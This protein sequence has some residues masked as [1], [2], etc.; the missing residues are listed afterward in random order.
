MTNGKNLH[1]CLFYSAGGSRMKIN[2]RINIINISML[3]ILMLLVAG[4]VNFTVRGVFEENIE[5]RELTFVEQVAEELTNPLQ[6]NDFANIQQVIDNIEMRNRYIRY[7]YVVDYDGSV[8]AHTF[9]PGIPVELT[10]ANPIPSGESFSI[11]ILSFEGESVHDIGA[12]IPDGI[13]AKVYFGFSREPILNSMNTI[14]NT[15]VSIFALFLLLSVVT[16]FFVTRTITR[17]IELLLEGTTKIGEGNIDYRID[18]EG[19]DEIEELAKGINRMTEDLKTSEAKYCSVADSVN[20]LIYLLDHDLHFMTCNR[21]SLECMG[22]SKEDVIGKPLVEIIHDPDKKKFYHKNLQ[23]ILRSGVPETH[24]VEFDV[25]GQKRYYTLTMTPVFGP[26]GKVTAIACVGCDITVRKQL[27]KKLQESEERYRKLVDQAPDSITVVREG[28]LIF[29]NPAMVK[30]LGA[31]GPEELLG[32]MI[33]DFSPPENRELLIERAQHILDTHEPAKL[34]EEKILRMDGSLLDVEVTASFI[35]YEGEPAIQTLVHDITERK[36]TEEEILFKHKQLLSIFDS[37]DE[38]VYIAD[39]VTYELLYYNEAFRSRFGDT[40]GDKCYKVIQDGTSPCSFCTNKYIFGKNLG[41]TYIWEWQNLVDSHW[42]RCIDKAIK[43]PDER[44]VRYEMAIDVTER[45]MFEEALQEQKEFAANLVQYSATPT[46]VLDSQHKVLYWNIACENLTGF[47]ASEVV[48]IED[49]WKSPYDHKRP[50]L[51]DIIISGES[52]NYLELYSIFGPSVHISNGLHA[53][54]WFQNVGGKKRYL[55]FD[56]API[57]NREGDLI[58]AV[59]TIQDFTER[60]RTEEALRKEKY[61]SETLVQS[62]PT[63]YVAINSR[64][65]TIMMNKAMLQAIGYTLEEVVGTDY[66]TTFV[67]EPERDMLLGIF[68]DIYSKK[69]TFNENSVLTKDGRELLVEWR[70]RPILKENNELDFFFGVGIDITERRFVE[71]ERRKYAEELRRSNELK[72]LF[73]DILR[74]DLLNP[75]SIVKGYI[76]VLLDVED[77][78]KKLQSIY[79]IKRNN[80]K[81]IDMIETASS[82]AKLESTEKF[83]FKE[84]DIR[85]IFKEV[86]KNFSSVLEEKK[87]ILEF[88]ADGTYL[89]MVNPVIEEAFANLL[90]NAI[91]YSPKESKIIIDIVDAG[92]NWKVSVTDFG[93]G[94]SDDDKPKLFERFR[95]VK[96]GAV[97]GTGLGL[98]IVKRLIALHG[99]TVGVEDNP[100]GQGSVFWVTVKKT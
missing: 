68:D 58:A 37:I 5:E 4:Y 23:K 6:N 93:E 72:D 98:A 77:N 82:F 66:L 60:K 47:K 86:V 75:A 92:K 32:K 27:E 73:T 25:M 100:A 40:V 36:R 8:V 84:M 16:S 17:P 91:K 49:H 33:M 54:D 11:Q 81:L 71:E 7:V 43:W 90:S 3:V 35:K 94:V 2:H 87:M 95:R 70:G 78:E 10:T 51:A 28:R 44:M 29:V 39:P 21:K 52:D 42:Y 55:I 24:E 18:V 79:A 46:F 15:I 96:K 85:V 31:N 1:I 13:D 64:G 88:A 89:S 50:T 22:A 12:L 26:E 57:Y 30:L 34:I 19:P 65:K 83:E 48:G 62:S 9:P 80:N 41:K 76:E 56:A 74:H 45:K 61:F 63:F 20:D 97:K 69:S 67:P 53:E 59:E 14:T 99:G 38:V